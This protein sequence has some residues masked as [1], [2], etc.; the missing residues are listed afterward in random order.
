M[1]A[2]NSERTTGHRAIGGVRARGREGG[3]VRSVGVVGS[4]RRG[5]RTITV[6]K[7]LVVRPSHWHRHRHHRRIYP[8]PPVLVLSPSIFLSFFLPVPYPAFRMPSPPAP[9]P[10]LVSLCQPLRS[11]TSPSSSPEAVRCSNNSYS[12]VFQ[13]VCTKARNLFRNSRTSESRTMIEGGS[14]FPPESFVEEKDRDTS[15][16]S[17]TKTLSLSFASRR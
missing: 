8:P 16:L 5:V 13:P 1:R 15:L 7:P 10:A 11:P 17:R 6:S 12:F 4:R 3:Q 14:S 9:S 2:I